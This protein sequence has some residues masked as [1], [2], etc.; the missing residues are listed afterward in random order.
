[1]GALSVSATEQEPPRLSVYNEV[2]AN[3]LN[4][5]VNFPALLPG[6]AGEGIQVEES[7]EEDPPST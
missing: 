2:V 1:M 7:S 5:S 3:Q 6:S 4:D